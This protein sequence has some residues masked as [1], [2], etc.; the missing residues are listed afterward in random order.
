MPMK[1]FS[2]V[3]VGVLGATGYSGQE[4]VRILAKHPGATLA[5]ASSQSEAGAMLSRVVRGAPEL[6]LTRLEDAELAACDVVL[7]CLPHGESAQWAGRAR[8]ASAKVVDLSADL[9]V[10][11]E[12]TPEW[13]RGAVY[14]LPELYREKIRGADVVANPGCYPTAALLALAPLLCAGNV[15]GP[16]IVNAASGVTGAGR[17]ARRE[18]L[19]AEVAEDFRA[20]GLGNTHRHLAEM[21]D[22]GARMNGG[23]APELVFVPHLL[24]V[25][26]GILETIHVT[27]REPMDD[28]V[29]LWRG[30]Y[31]HEPFVEVMEDRSPTLA[32]VVGTNRV[33][34]GV[35][36]VAGVSAPMLTVVAAIDNLVKGAAGQAV[37]NVN[38]M[39]GLDETEGLA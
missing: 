36:A 37:Q 30:A 15:A 33:V 22:Q 25:R 8:E 35:A 24:P 12:S 19:F 21:R 28:P 14:G 27:L 6:P 18:Y 7:C 34:I 9:R 13:G 29:A 32:D 39:F 10:P 2:L 16:V 23:T 38:L 17:A 1:G 31:G 26:R 5:L 3:R 11:G 20:Y 4:A